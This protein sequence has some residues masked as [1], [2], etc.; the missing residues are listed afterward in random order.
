M[1]SLRPWAYAAA[2]ISLVGLDGAIGVAIV[3]H[4]ASFEL[5]VMAIVVSGQLTKLAL[6]PQQGRYWGG[7]VRP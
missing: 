4:D 2:V 5:G 7:A 6:P 1:D 3:V